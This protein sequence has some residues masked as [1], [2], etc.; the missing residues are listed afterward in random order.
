MTSSTNPLDGWLLG[1][2]GYPLKSWLITP[3]ITPTKRRQCAFNSVFSSAR[4]V[5]ERTFGSLKIHFRCLDRS[6]GTLQ[7]SPQSVSAF[8]VAC[9]VLHNTAMR[10][11]Y[12]FDLMEETLQDLRR[13][14]TEL[15][16]LYQHGEQ[17]SARERRDLL[18]AQIF[19]EWWV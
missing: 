13:R 5:I 14:E 18:A 10:H 15:H 7:Y 16:V 4:S 8:F 3:Y 12:Y 19:P 9:C 6:G 1:D 2:N 17:Q 11:G